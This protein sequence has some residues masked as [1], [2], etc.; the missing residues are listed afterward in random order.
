M[1]IKFEGFYLI[2]KVWGGLSLITE[3]TASICVK[4]DNGKNLRASIK[5]WEGLIW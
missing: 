2:N 5:V 3:E 4:F 1:L